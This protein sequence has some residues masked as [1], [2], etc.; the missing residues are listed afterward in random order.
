LLSTDGY[1]NSFSSEAG[2]FQAGTDI[3]NMLAAE[4]GHD[5]VNE[6]LKSWLEEATRMGSGDDCTVGVIYRPDSLKKSDTAKKSEIVAKASANSQI[7]EVTA[8]TPS[9]LLLPSTENLDDVTVTITIKK[10]KNKTSA[11]PA[12]TINNSLKNSAKAIDE[13]AADKESK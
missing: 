10:D 3:L 13:D 12:V 11:P 2:F 9:N 1:L 7:E 4:N 6:N 5:A 8:E